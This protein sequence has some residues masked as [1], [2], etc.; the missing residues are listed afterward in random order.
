MIAAGANTRKRGTQAL[1][2]S[3]PALGVGASVVASGKQPVNALKGA[4]VLSRLQLPAILRP[5]MD[6][7]WRYIT[8]YGGRGAAKSRSVGSVLTLYSAMAP[9]R[10]LCA[11][12]W[13]T[14]IND[15]V[16]SL[17][18]SEIKRLNLSH[19]FKY[20]RTYIE[21]KNG[22]EFI[23]E[24][25]RVNPDAIKGIEGIDYCWV[26]EA[27]RVSEASW[28]YLIPTI[29]NERSQ[30]FIT[31]NPEDDEDPTY[32]RFV[33]NPPKNCLTIKINWHDNPWFPFVL[34]QERLHCLETDPDAYDWIWDGNTRKISEAVIFKGKFSIE[35]FETPDSAV[36]YH[37]AD[38]GF[39]ADPTVLVR[40][41]E[42][43]GYLYVD[44][45]CYARNLDLDRIASTWRQAI[46]GCDRWQVLADNS[47]PQTIAHV[48]DHGFRIGP[49]KKWPG[50]IED[51]IKHLRSY[52]KIIVH[53]RCYYT[54]QEMK[55]YSYKTD[56]VTDEVLPIVLDKNNHCIDALRYGVD[57]RIRKRRRGVI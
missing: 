41:F 29:R 49:A 26:E 42:K 31:F 38:W 47:Q 43:D 56:R 51:G 23:F 10:T 32:K 20:G 5:I 40:C 19:R 46:P 4:S 28:I 54:G 15:S 36:F 13:Q 9:R 24:G 55:L 8:L 27:Q 2:E 14:S 53:E 44:H 11:R 39:G 18:K 35:T 34:E 48:K 16:M 22:S 52:K 7:S 1:M 17:I 33:K 21:G 3:F 45:E 50:S 25:L 37:G 12:E 6:P 57:R 30:I